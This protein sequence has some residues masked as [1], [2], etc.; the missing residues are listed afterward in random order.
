[1]LDKEED[2]EIHCN[3]DRQAVQDESSAE[4]NEGK[5]KLCEL[6]RGGWMRVG[7]CHLLER[8]V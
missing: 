2:R 5:E 3:R 1:M 4:R 6:R 7:G 8:A